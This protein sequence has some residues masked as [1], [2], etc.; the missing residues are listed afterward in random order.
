MSTELDTF[1]E[2]GYEQMDKSL[3]HLSD[4]LSKIRAGKASPAMVSS[5]MVDYYGSPTPLPQVA[6]VS[7]SDARTITIQPWEKGMLAKIEKS[8]FESNMGMTPM[9][10]GEIILLTIPPLTEERRII[11]VKQCKAL[12]EDAKVS[13]RNVRHKLMDH[14][15]KEVKDGFPEDIG[16][17]KE[18]EV[19]KFVEEHTEKVN[20]LIEAKEREILKV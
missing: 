18:T 1:L 11:L 15:K 7:T 20:K 17:K 14:I 19:Q 3:E 6:N 5:L 16:K 4:E 13:V 9:N 10:N 8:I 2:I 12:G